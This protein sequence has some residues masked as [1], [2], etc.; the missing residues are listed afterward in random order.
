MEL[1]LILVLIGM[2]CGGSKKKKSRRR[3][4]K[5]DDSWLDYAWFNDHDRRI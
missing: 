2:F 4:T 3:R 1:I 5:K